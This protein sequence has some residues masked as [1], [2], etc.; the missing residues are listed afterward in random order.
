MDSA[1]YA[2]LEDDALLHALLGATPVVDLELEDFLTAARARLLAAVA[3]DGAATALPL[4]FAC[5]LAQ[6][7]FINEYVFAQAPGETA[8]VAA[9]ASRVAAALA[10][11]TAPA[12]TDLVAVASYRPLHALERAPALLERRWPA[13]V[14]ALLALQVAAPLEEWRLRPGIPQLTPV[15]D[16]VSQAV[17]AQYEENPYPRWIKAPRAQACRPVLDHLRSWFPHA[18]LP[19]GA[20]RA[21]PEILVAGCG[22]GQHP[23]D[24]AQSVAGARVLAVDLSLASLA[25]AKRKTRELGIESIEYAQ[26]DLLALAA[27]GRRFDVIEASGVLHHLADPFA[28]WRALLA[29]L[30]PGGFMKLGFYSETARRDIVRARRLIAGAG[31][32]ATPAGIRDAR[33]YLRRVARAERIESVLQGDF[34]STSGCRDWLFHVQEQ[35]TTLAAIDAF[36]RAE[37]LALLGFQVDRA[38]LAQYRRAFPG[39][40]AAVDLGNWQRFERE[41]PDT[42]GGMYQFWVRKR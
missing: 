23:I 3:A 5:A 21:R 35:H 7:C 8:A 13:A 19:A 28:G 10:A 16:A 25:Y 29:L 20:A 38:T 39:D 42:F 37:R 34:F 17:R 4:R 26:A 33:Q 14:E 31:F 1:A 40:A 12:L 6:Q 24:T 9:V 36:L 41:R 22:T 30:Q 2:P 18:D 11:G 32:A 15:D 27:P